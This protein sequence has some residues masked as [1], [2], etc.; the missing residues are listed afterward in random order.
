MIEINRNGRPERQIVSV[1]LNQN[2]IALI[3]TNELSVVGSKS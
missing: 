1:P 2:I 3:T